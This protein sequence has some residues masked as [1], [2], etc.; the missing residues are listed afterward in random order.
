MTERV[1]LIWDCL[2][3]YWSASFGALA[4]RAEVTAVI[5]PPDPLAPYD[6]AALR[7][8]GVTLVEPAWPPSFAEL[9]RVVDDVQP[10]VVCSLGRYAALLRTLHHARD[11]RRVMWTDVFW[12]G[13]WRQQVFRVLSPAF[14][15]YC[16]DAAWVPGELFADFPRQLGFSDHRIGYGSVPVNTN[17]LAGARGGSDARWEKPSFAYVGRL[18]HDKGLS[19]LAGAYRRYRTEVEDPWPLRIAGT[20]PDPGGL[21]GIDGVEMLGFVQPDEVVGIYRDAAA[22]VLPSIFDYWGTVSMEACAAGLPVIVSEGCRGWLEQATD[23][24]GFHV[25]PGDAA[26]LATAMRVVHEASVEQ[27]RA[28]GAASAAISDRYTPAAWADALLALAAAAG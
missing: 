26:A 19:I 8:A 20:G 16:F 27:R 5:K 1:V 17:R 24:N 28:W 2:T 13:T 15:R 6:Y 11:A 4:E 12:K 22:F 10:T 3:D 9:R 18:H 14:R 7:P 21:D 25:P 23:A